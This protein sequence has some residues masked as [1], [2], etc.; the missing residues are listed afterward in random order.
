M[1]N[2]ILRGLVVSVECKLEGGYM[3]P[4][5]KVSV[6]IERAMSKKVLVVVMKGK[7]N[8]PLINCMRRIVNNHEFNNFK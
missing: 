2:P 6:S 4:F 1:A 5:R 3:P 8:M 7:M